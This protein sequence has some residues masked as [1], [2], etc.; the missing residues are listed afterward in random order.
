MRFA[1]RFRSAPRTWRAVPARQ[2]LPPREPSPMPAGESRLTRSSTAAATRSGATR[3]TSSGSIRLAGLPSRRNSP[4]SSESRNGL[5]PVAWLHA[6]HNSALASSPMSARTTFPTAD[7]TERPRTKYRRAR[8]HEQTNP[9]CGRCMSRAGSNGQR[10][11]YRQ[12]GEPIRE[13]QQETEARVRR[14]TARRRPR[15][16]TGLVLRY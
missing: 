8:L 1:D 16:P 13:V 12:T 10:H 3:P 4:R 9:R 5:P 2:E 6:R 15:G 11:H 14:P 7:S